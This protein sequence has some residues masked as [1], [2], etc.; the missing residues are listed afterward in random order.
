VQLINIEVSRCLNYTWISTEI[1]C[2]AAAISQPLVGILLT[3]AAGRWLFHHG[4]SDS[5]PGEFM[6]DSWWTKWHEHVAL[7]V[8]SVLLVEPLFGHCPMSIC[9]RPK[10]CAISHGQTTIITSSVLTWKVYL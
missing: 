6:C 10:I 3:Q 4:D 2:H 7:R 5:I 1:A 9:R 8:S